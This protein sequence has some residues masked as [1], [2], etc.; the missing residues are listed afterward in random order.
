MS[1][2]F[3]IEEVELKEAKRTALTFAMAQSVVGAC[4]PVAISVGGLAGF[5]LL[6]ADKTFATLPVTGYNIGVAVGALPAAMIMRAIGRRK[7]FSTGAL[8][9]SL[10]GALAA[11][12]LILH[13]F[14]F[15]VLALA[16]IGVGGAFTQQY[17]FAAADAAPR[18]FKPQAISWVLSGGIFAAIIGP[19]AVI[20]TKDFLAPVSFAGAFLSVVVLGVIGTA[21]LSTL[22][23]LPSPA[24]DSEEMTGTERTTREIISQPRF[25]VAFTCAV[26]TY[27]LMSFVMTGAPIAMVDCG[28]TANDATLGISWHVMAMF[29]PSF[30]TGKLIARFGKEKIVAAG[31]LLLIACALVALSGVSLGQFWLALILLGVGWNFGFIG[32]TAMLTDTYRPCE[33]SKIQGIHDFALFTTVAIASFGSGA[34]L[35]AYGWDMLSWITLPVAGFCL[36]VLLVQAFVTRGN[37]KS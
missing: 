32:A 19:Q 4:A 37:N 25:L 35:N 22:T 31:L 24:A 30:F 36:L 29:G 7:G 16:V 6:G 10:G 8:V 34:T 27:A 26:T 33:K 20:W 5:Y 12:G 2:V 11:T 21:I 17:R 14:L 18:S 28:L 23:H 13:N 3:E 15:F 9:T 1:D